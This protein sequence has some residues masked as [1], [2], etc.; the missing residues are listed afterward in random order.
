MQ[1]DRALG[2]CYVMSQTQVSD[3]ANSGL[4]PGPSGTW[5]VPRS[6]TSIR[7]GI[8]QPRWEVSFLTAGE[9]WRSRDG[10]GYFCSSCSSF[11]LGINYY[12]FINL[13][14][15]SGKSDWMN[16]KNWILFWVSN[17]PGFSFRRKMG[18]VS[19]FLTDG[20]SPSKWGHLSLVMQ[21]FPPN[22]L[23]EHGWAAQ[24][25]PPLRAKRWLQKLCYLL[26]QVLSPVR[27]ELGAGG[28][29]LAAQSHSS[30]L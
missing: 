20:W 29:Q 14:G 27:T 12:F 19:L 23:Q 13:T 26:D 1:L 16:P 21:S 3:G 30:I 25:Q 7:W 6:P 15:V 9:G 18:S 22:G 10:G 8:C 24:T 2:L 11:L 17:S 4:G 28:S 5:V